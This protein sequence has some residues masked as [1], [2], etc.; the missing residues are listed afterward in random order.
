[1]SFE[2]NRE[3]SDFEEGVFA[4]IQTQGCLKDWISLQ[5]RE[6]D[7]NQKTMAARSVEDELYKV[8]DR[9]APNG[10]FSIWLSKGAEKAKGEHLQKDYRS[11]KAVRESIEHEMVVVRADIQKAIGRFLRDAVNPES[12]NLLAKESGIK[13]D[14]SSLLQE[15]EKNGISVWGPH[16]QKQLSSICELQNES[17]RL[18]Q[19]YSTAAAKPGQTVRSASA[20]EK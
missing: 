12:L 18:S 6:A 1:M 5:H 2:P 17:A 9:V 7:L 15:L 16:A 10:V 19:V 8:Y 14:L 11:A 20:G 3:I 13:R 4:A